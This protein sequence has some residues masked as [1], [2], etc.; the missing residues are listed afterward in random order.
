MAWV[1]LPCVHYATLLGGWRVELQTLIVLGGRA[2]IKCIS[3]V[4]CPPGADG[5][6]VVDKAFGSDWCNWCF[7]E[8]ISTVDLLVGRFSGIMA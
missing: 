3:F 6:V 8:V 4:R 1:K 2:D 5:G 7:V